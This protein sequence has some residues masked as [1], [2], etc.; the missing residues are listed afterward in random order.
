MISLEQFLENIA[1]I[2]VMHILAAFCQA[3]FQQGW[4]DMNIRKW[5]R[6]IPTT[7]AGH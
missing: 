6:E 2:K 5:F 7:N 4:A 1:R 3:D